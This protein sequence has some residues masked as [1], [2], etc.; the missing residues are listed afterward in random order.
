L[1][2]QSHDFV[3]MARTLDRYH[4]L[5]AHDRI[6]DNMYVYSV[7]AVTQA[8]FDFFGDDVGLELADTFLR[9]AYRSCRCRDLCQHVARLT[10]QNRFGFALIALSS[11]TSNFSKYPQL[12]K[13]AELSRPTLI[14][15]IHDSH[16]GPID[17]DF[18]YLPKIRHASEEIV[19]NIEVPSDPNNSQALNETH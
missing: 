16:D 18:P 17:P 2:L 8:G 3:L 4:D 12:N 19:A 10:D 7:E 15:A 11:L 14:A 5:L 9:K 13:W 1:A 6:D